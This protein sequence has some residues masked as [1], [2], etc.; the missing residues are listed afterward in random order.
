[1]NK[2]FLIAIT[3]IT[4]AN[5]MVMKYPGIEYNQSIQRDKQRLLFETHDPEWDPS[6]RVVERKKRG[7]CYNYTFSQFLNITQPLKTMGCQDWITELNVLQFFKQIEKPRRGCLTV[8][9]TNKNDLTIQHVAK[10]VNAD[11]NNIQVISKWGINDEIVW[12]P[13]FTMPPDF[14]DAAF[15][16]DLDKQYTQDFMIQTIEQKISSSQHI[17]K[18]LP[19]IQND[20]YR[21]AKEKEPKYYDTFPS[22]IDLL[23]E[24]A[25]VI[26]K[27]FIGVDIN[28]RDK[29][30]RTALMLAATK[31]N[32]DMV[33]LL[34]EYGA[35]AN[36]QDSQGKTAIELA[37]EKINVKVVQFLR[38]KTN[39]CII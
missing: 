26:I 35:D 21:L 19:Q 3:C 16:F 36:L 23:W 30:N 31:G 4:T 15:F 25:F 24:K 12:H 11:P 38:K 18:E 29:K 39:N 8:F 27:K 20:L 1:M 5:G 6:C 14:G 37:Y 34:I 17:Q 7:V 28:G 10:V 13:L 33:E 9:T 2:L 22:G 32:L